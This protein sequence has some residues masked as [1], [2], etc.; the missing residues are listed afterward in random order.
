MQR[1]L[2]WMAL[3]VA[4][5]IAALVALFPATLALRWFLPSVPGLVIGPADGTVW[6]GHIAGVRYSGLNAG[7]L[8]W[9]LHA[10]SLL[11]L[12][13]SADIV[14]ERPDASPLAFSMQAG[15]DGV[16]TLRDIAGSTS[17]SE[18]ERAGIVP[19]NVASGDVLARFSVLELAE[20][21]P[22]AA[23]G[24]LGVSG[25]QTAFLPGTPLGSYQ[26]EVTTT[27]EGIRVNFNDVEAPLR[28]AGQALLKPD[29][30]YSVSGTVTPG[31]ATPDALRRGLVLL[32]RPDASGRYQFG[33]DGRL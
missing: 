27:D 19:R 12:H 28:I 30:S 21:T 13:A 5:Y 4:I 2:K 9:N 33:F 8:H 22:R 31:T 11:T 17:I 6:D 32:G 26:G 18:L 29:G 15:A 1:K 7:T 24:T 20:G 14:L 16:V 23:E 25:L 10:L 3:A